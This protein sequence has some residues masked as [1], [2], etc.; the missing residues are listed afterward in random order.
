MKNT[1]KKDIIQNTKK[2]P[3]VID[4]RKKNLE[5]ELRKNILLKSR[6]FPVVCL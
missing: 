2:T 6:D 5:N 1:A 4:F 3:S